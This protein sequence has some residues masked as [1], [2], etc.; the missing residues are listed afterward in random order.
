MPVYDTTASIWLGRSLVVER[1]QGQERAS[2]LPVVQL[3]PRLIS[4]LCNRLSAHELSPQVREGRSGTPV[5]LTERR[6]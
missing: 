4:A 2:H 3:G 6:F 5:E 1:G